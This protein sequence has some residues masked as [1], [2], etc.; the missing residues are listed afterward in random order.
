MRLKYYLRGIAAGVVVSTCILTISHNMEMRSVKNSAMTDDE[1][2]ASAKELG[3]VYEDDTTKVSDGKWNTT[4][5]DSVKQENNDSTKAN[6][7]QDWT[8]NNSNSGGDN[9]DTESGKVQSSEDEAKQA[10]SDIKNKADEM[11][12]NANKDLEEAFEVEITITS[13]MTSDKVAEQLKEKGVIENSDEFDS[14]M[15][16][17]GYDDKI[18]VGDHTVSSDDTYEEIA[19]K[20]MGKQ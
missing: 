2:I 14:F 5:G 16:E 4:S 8:S 19:N 11:L 10:E 15:M 7:E 9:E 12:D 6:N 20:L 18:W 13:G 3:M 1:I 17:N